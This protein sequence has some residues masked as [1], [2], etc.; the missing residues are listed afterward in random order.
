MPVWSVQV[1]NGKDQ[2]VE[3]G[4]LITESG[5]LLAMA[6]DGLLLLAWAPGEWRTVRCIDGALR[7]LAASPDWPGQRLAPVPSGLMHP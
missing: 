2:T 7:N 1:A 4:M 6:E 5:S 3:A